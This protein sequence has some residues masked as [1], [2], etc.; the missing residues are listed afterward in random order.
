MLVRSILTVLGGAVIVV[1]SADAGC[2][3]C[4]AN[5]PAA[6]VPLP[7]G[8]ATVGP[9]MTGDMSY[10]DSYGYSGS[11]FSGQEPFQSYRSDHTPYAGGHINQVAPPPGTI[12]QTYQLPS[13]P[14]P[15]KMHPRSSVLKVLAEGAVEVEMVS[16]NPMRTEDLVKGHR[17]DETG[18]WV[19]KTDPLIPGNPHI[20]RVRA[21]YGEGVEH[22]DRYVRLIMGR[23]SALSY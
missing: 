13:S 20:Y 4:Q 1:A 6:L 8:H 2:K 12:G 18:V 7:A 17:D 9:V 22:K 3:S 11:A 23:V 10:G 21:K 15:A 14:V 5:A 19:F 16:T